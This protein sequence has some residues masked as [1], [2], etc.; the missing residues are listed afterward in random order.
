LIFALKPE[1]V[2]WLLVGTCD[3]VVPL[4]ALPPELLVVVELD[5]VL[6]DDA[7]AG[8]APSR[9]VATQAVMSRVTRTVS[10]VGLRG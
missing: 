4:I 7:R 1:T 2:G 5:P 10:F 8:A 9:S 3:G 6:E